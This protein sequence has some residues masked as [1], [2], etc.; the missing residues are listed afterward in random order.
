MSKK[1]KKQKRASH[2]KKEILKRGWRVTDSSGRT[3][4]ECPDTGTLVRER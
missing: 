2:Y 4:V 3:Y 1:S